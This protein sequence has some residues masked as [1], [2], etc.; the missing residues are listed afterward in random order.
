MVTRCLRGGWAGIFGIAIFSIP[1]MAVPWMVS[2]A[3]E[4][5]AASA[6][7]SAAVSATRSENPRI[8]RVISLAGDLLY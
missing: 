5:S 1:R 2:A 4:P 3:N 8:W 7:V 6:V